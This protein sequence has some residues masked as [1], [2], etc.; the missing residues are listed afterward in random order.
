MA[1]SLVGL[2]AYLVS[3]GFSPPW[4]TQKTSFSKSLMWAASLRRLV[5]VTI[6]GNCT[7]S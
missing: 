3:R 4:V 1:V 6:I 2:R 5:S 7:S